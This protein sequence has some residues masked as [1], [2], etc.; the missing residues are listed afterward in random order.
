MTKRMS[1]VFCGLAVML[2]TAGA[3]SAQTAT[4]KTK[5]AAKKTGPID[6]LLVLGDVEH[7]RRKKP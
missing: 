3:A 2:M 7:W 4:E 5:T 1:V 6:P